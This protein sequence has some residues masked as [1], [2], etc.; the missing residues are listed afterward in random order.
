[1][2]A[3]NLNQA[4][5]VELP[6]DSAR[7]LAPLRMLAGLEVAADGAAAWLRG[8]ALDDALRIRLLSLPANNRFWRD[9]AGQ[10]TPWGCITPVGHLPAVDWQPL[11]AWQAVELPARGW[12]AD[13]PQAVRLKLVRDAGEQP[14]GALLMPWHLW[15]AYVEHAPQVRLDPLA[16]ALD[17]ESRVIVRGAWLPA[18]PGTQL[19]D[20]QGILVPAG[21]G[22]MLRLDPQAVRS[23]FSLADGE[24]AFWPQSDRWER[25][26][27]EAWVKA[28]RA[29]VRETTREVAGE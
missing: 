20:Q 15:A 7:A 14:G 6:R 22:W 8:T 29:A 3:S 10:L 23:L 27:A 13:P 28:T 11:R 18:L 24:C 1:M 12:P 9:A 16:F 5:A 21:W 17:S 4:W 25:I 19:S 2:E 26:T